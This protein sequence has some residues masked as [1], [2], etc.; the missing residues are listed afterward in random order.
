[1]EDITGFSMKDCLNFSGLGW[2]YFNSLTTEEDEPFC[3]YNDNNM[4][5]FVRQSIKGGR[6]CAPN[7]IINRKFV[8]I[9]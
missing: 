4:R 3:T 7:N 8:T 1:M 2:K 5:W 6:V 9:S